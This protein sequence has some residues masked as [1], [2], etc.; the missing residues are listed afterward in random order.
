M[1]GYRA[2]MTPSQFFDKGYTERKILMVLH[3]YDI[4]KAARKGIKINN[5]LTRIEA[6]APHASDETIKTYQVVDHKAQIT[7]NMV[8]KINPDMQR[9]QLTVAEQFDS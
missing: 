2:E 5:K 9:R 6:G 7:K 4:L 1:F 3:I 8:F